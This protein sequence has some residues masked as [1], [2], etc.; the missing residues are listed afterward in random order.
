MFTIF[1]ATLT[2]SALDL[3]GSYIEG[4]VLGDTSANRYVGIYDM[5]GDLFKIH[6]YTGVQKK[7]DC[8]AL[9]T[10][11]DGMYTAR[12]FIWNDKMQPLDKTERSTKFVY[13]PQKMYNYERTIGKYNFNG[14]V[15]GDEVNFYGQ[16]VYANISPEAELFVNGKQVLFTDVNVSKYII[17][18]T[19]T[20]FLIENYDSQNKVYKKISVNYEESVWVEGQDD[21]IITFEFSTLDTVIQLDTKKAGV[22]YTATLD[23]QPINMSDI[24]KPD[25]LNIEYDMEAGFDKSSYYNITVTRR[26]VEGMANS[27]SEEYKTGEFSNKIYHILYMN[28]DTFKLGD[29]Y[30]LYLDKYDRVL[31]YLNHNILYP[32]VGILDVIYLSEDAR[33]YKVGVIT[34]D[35]KM[36][37]ELESKQKYEELAAILWTNNTDK[38]KRPEQDRIV[39]FKVNSLNVFSLA[40]IMSTKQYVNDV[41]KKPQNKKTYHMIGDYKLQDSCT[42]I[43]SERDGQ[44]SVLSQNELYDGSVYEMY[45]Y[46]STSE[47]NEYRFALITKK[48]D[49]VSLIAMMQ[50]SSIVSDENGDGVHEIAVVANGTET[51]YLVDPSY[52]PSNQ[53]FVYTKGDISMIGLNSD[54]EVVN[55]T[56]VF[57]NNLSSGYSEFRNAVMAKSGENGKFESLITPPT[58]EL[59]DSTFAFGPISDKYIISLC[60]ARPGV[61]GI[62][63]MYQDTDYTLLDSTQVYVYDYSKSENNRIYVG[64]NG[65]IMETEGISSSSDQVDWNDVD[66]NDR[67]NFAFVRAD[68]NYNAKEVFVILSDY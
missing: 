25:V 2:A 29:R 11:A 18:N 1:F 52:I 24:K 38:I 36:F 17:Y 59:A 66:I 40:E 56:P 13:I 28:Q 63:N 62:S 45:L 58:E 9:P 41:Y 67:I 64:T 3:P 44:F 7:I 4:D 60:L 34:S 19:G 39:S 14:G 30:D 15:I 22:T 47:S 46:N 35:G 53:E 12:T 37:Y 32:R 65:D 55:I 49:Y 27:Y 31:G 8:T 23:G 26:T 54:G 61:D 51:K 43:V 20:D 48:P 10:D 6:A 42:F 68:D 57:D 16:N 5:Y 33:T 50:S 21:G